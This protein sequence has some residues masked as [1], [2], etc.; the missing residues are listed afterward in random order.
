MCGRHIRERAVT[1]ALQEKTSCYSG[2]RFESTRLAWIRSFRDGRVFAALLHAN[3]PQIISY[4]EVCR[5]R[6]A[7]LHL[8]PVTQAVPSGRPTAVCPQMDI[9]EP[10]AR[11]ARVFQLAQE[12]WGVSQLI[13]PD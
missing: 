6:R 2:V 12:H 11:V 8:P 5:T 10:P 1:L 3:E 9:Q 13:D 4:D 7:L